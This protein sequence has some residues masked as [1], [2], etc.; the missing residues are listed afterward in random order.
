[1]DARHVTKLFDD[2]WN[3][4]SKLDAEVKIFFEARG[5]NS[6]LVKVD[7]SGSSV[8]IKHNIPEILW[9]KKLHDELCETFGVELH[10]FKVERVLTQTGKTPLTNVNW[11]YSSASVGS[12]F[13]LNYKEC[14]DAYKESV[15]IEYKK[16]VGNGANDKQ[17]I[18]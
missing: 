10:F 2:A 11:G 6:D 5:I 9:T 14:V 16:M 12:E 3:A 17:E 1:M 18:Y 7:V 15:P 4:Y 8:H 13:I